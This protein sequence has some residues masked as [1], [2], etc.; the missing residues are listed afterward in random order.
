MKLSCD[1]AILGGGFG[2]SLLALIARR[3]GRSV[4]LLERD[5][6]PRFAIGESSTPLTNLLLEEI[7]LRHELPELLPLTKWGTWQKAHPQTGCGLKRGFTFYHHE[8]GQ[9]FRDDAARCRQLLVAASPHDR[10]ADTHWY[11]PDF[12]QL[13]F[14]AAEKRGAQCLEETRLDGVV[15]DAAGAVIN[16]RHA[17]QAL[18]VRARFVVDASGPRGALHRA[19]KLP[20]VPLEPLPRTEALFAHFHG[21]RRLDDLGISSDA[22]APPYP[23]DDAALHHVFPG[24]WIW[25]LRFNNGITS[26]GVAM[27]DSLADELKL[28]EGVLAWTR[29]L[30]RLP[31]VRDQFAAAEAVTPFIHAPRLSFCSGTVTGANWALLPSA[32][33][34]VD[35]L[36]STGFPLTLLGITRLATIL[37]QG[38]QK[39]DFSTRLENYAAHTRSELNLVAKLVATLYQAM[40]DFPRFAALTRLY[41]AAASFTE[42]V[43]RLGHAGLAGNSFLMSDHAVFGPAMRDCLDRALAGLPTVALI[44]QI[45]QT[46]APFDVAGLNDGAR[47]NWHPVRADDLLAAAGKLGASEGDIR[48]LLRRCGFDGR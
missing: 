23:V 36:L 34:F 18:E 7:A 14:R 16:A 28:A 37:E 47:R 31:T 33:G 20:E 42:T 41:F 38:W 48:D 46:I 32:A 40:N 24:G 9:P 44:E 25:V 12:D 4:V 1:L 45:S 11:R 17:G 21:V 2:G 26:A 5:R 29:L 19:L 43:R 13:L 22:D 15:F 35:P 6:H 3:Q 10:I 8:F 27:T 39:K 30:D